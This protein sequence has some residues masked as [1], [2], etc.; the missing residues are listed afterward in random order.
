[1][2]FC[3]FTVELESSIIQGRIESFLLDQNVSF[4]CD[5]VGTS[6]NFQCNHSDAFF[7]EGK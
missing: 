4:N 1:M 5:P 2:Y 6:L 3:Q 7:S